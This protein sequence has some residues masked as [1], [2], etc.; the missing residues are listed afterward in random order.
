MSNVKRFRGIL[1]NECRFQGEIVADPVF[2]GDYAFMTLRTTY[3]N[4]DGNGQFVE[5]D[6]DVPLMV[7]PDG[8]INV[9]RSNVKAQ[10]QMLVKGH[11][12]TWQAA[13][14]THHAFVV[15]QLKL[16]SKPFEGGNERQGNVPPLPH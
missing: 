1:E 8:P 4:R 14:S 11:Y 3:L 13:G 10:R 15:K 12:K 16:G 9:V 6:V 2:Q 5:V 7:E